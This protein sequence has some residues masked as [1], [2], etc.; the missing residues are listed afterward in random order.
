MLAPGIVSIRRRFAAQPVETSPEI[1]ISP[2]TLA[3]I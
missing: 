1:L 3:W 2:L